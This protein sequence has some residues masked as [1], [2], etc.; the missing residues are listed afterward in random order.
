MTAL[1]L[2][3]A[4][5]FLNITSTTSDAE[6]LTF[7]DAAESEIAKRVGPL[8]TST[9]TKRVPGY[10]WNLHLPIYPAASLTTVTVAGSVTALTLADLYLDTRTG[11]VSYTS[12]AFFSAAAYDVTYVAGRTTVSADLLMKIKVVLKFLWNSQRGPTARPGAGGPD[13]AAQSLQGLLDGLFSDQDE[14][15]PGLA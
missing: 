7:I 2:T 12:G 11:A 8:S 14:L 4:K 10:A 9:V 3:D 13:A 15:L 1:G 6:L 5:T